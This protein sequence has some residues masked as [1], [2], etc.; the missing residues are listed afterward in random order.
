MNNTQRS[1]SLTLPSYSSLNEKECK[2]FWN[3]ECEDL[4]SYSWLPKKT[5]K[6]SNYLEDNSR[7]WVKRITPVESETSVLSILTPSVSINIEG[8]KTKVIASKKIRIYPKNPELYNQAIVLNRRAYNLAIECYKEDKYKDENNKPLDLRP[9]IKE[10]VLNEQRLSGSA[11][12]ANLVCESVRAAGKTF[13]I[14][15]S[16]NKKLKGSKK[17]FSKLHFKSAKRSKQSFIVDKL[18]K[19]LAPYKGALGDVYIS[20]CVPLEAIGKQATVTREKGRWFIQVQQHIEI[21]PEIQ[22]YV[23]CVG[24]D[25]GTRT[26]ATCYSLSD[27]LEVGVDFS[28]DKL[29]PLLIRVD[30]LI[31]DR[32]KILNQ[33]KGI[34]F[35]DY[36]QWARDRIKGF[37]KKINKLQC[38]KDDLVLDL[39]NK[40]AYELVM[41][42]DVIFLPTFKTQ[43][44]VRNSKSSLRK[45]TKRQM[46]AL[47]HYNFKLRLKWY[48][49]KYGKVVVDCNEAYTSKTRS[50]DGTIDENLGSSKIIKGEGFSV[51]RDVNGARNIYLKH[52]TR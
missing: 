14:V 4:Q 33:F 35:N 34:A 27:V 21:E 31:S 45:T 24:I 23:K 36:P 22:G 43:Q 28:K 29:L 15:C 6:N 50:W 41:N 7:F 37:N 32:Q 26:F 30:K 39:H 11:Y 1:K 3:Q 2:P 47:N 8:E 19:C 10:I 42:Y 5:N 44:M 18:P 51:D 16:K 9:Q 46:L 48:A 12:S 17:G 25:Q 52:V 38:R 49:K 13:S 40:L 20:E